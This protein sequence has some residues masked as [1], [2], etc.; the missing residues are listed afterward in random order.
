VLDERVVWLTS[1]THFTDRLVE[2]HLPD[3]GYGL[4]TS[5]R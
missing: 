1:D 2:A 4:S 3:T 5:G